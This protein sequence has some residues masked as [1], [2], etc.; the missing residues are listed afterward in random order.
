[1]TKEQYFTSWRTY[2]AAA[3]SASENVH[4]TAAA[5]HA[6]RMMKLEKEREEEWDKGVGENFSGR[7]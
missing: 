3:L 6:D 7:R 1:M 5:Q 2:A 4:P